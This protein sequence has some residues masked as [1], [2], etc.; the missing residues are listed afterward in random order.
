VSITD[1]RFDAALAE[2][3]A[4][5]AEERAGK[6]MWLTHHWPDEY[7]RCVVIGGRHVCR[8]CLVLYS[9]SFLV[10]ALLL[11][12][13]SLWPERLEL[14]LIWGLCIP[15]SIDFVG[16]QLGLF[17]YSARRQLAVTLLLGPALGAGFAHEL[18]DSWSWE[19]WGPVLVFCTLWFFA[20]LTG[21][22]RKK[23]GREKHGRTEQD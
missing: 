21:R 19:F 11:A 14:W 18:D 5:H 23:Q 10:A 20:A 2:I 15:A 13:V 6:Q 22:G 1:D 7:E 9:S 17:R 3:E 4:R 8:R 16:E 12:G